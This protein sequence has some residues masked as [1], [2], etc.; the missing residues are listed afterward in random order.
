MSK[1]SLVIIGSGIKAIEQVTIEGLYHLRAAEKVLY[2]VCDPI[3]AQWIEEVNPESE[4]LDSFYEDDK[5][6]HITYREMVEKILSYV[7][8]GVNLC[9]CFEGHP[10]VFVCASHEALRIARREGF[11]A[12]M[13]AGISALDCLFAD[14]GIDPGEHGCQSYDATDFLIYKRVP[15][16]TSPLILW[17]ID[18]IGDLK[19]FKSGYDMRNLPV[20]VKVLQEYYGAEH[21]VF[22]YQAA[23][24]PICSPVIKR[25]SLNLLSGS[26][27]RGSTLYIPPREAP[28]V[29]IEMARRIGWANYQ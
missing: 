19:F 14:L 16:V 4:S 3:T 24:L 21:E 29:N 28:Q 7:R 18:C 2:G 20:L 1:G 23:I 15:C 11:S 9:V 17:Q 26:I 27:A 5:P 13:L 12:R 8:Q 6:R 25:T 10:G 22:V